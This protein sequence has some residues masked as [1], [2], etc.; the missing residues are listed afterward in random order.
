MTHGLMLLDDDS[1]FKA[2]MQ[3]DIKQWHARN[4][5]SQTAFQ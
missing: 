5:A 1:G 4:D 3:F 2:I